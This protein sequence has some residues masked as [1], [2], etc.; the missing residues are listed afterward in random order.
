[1]CIINYIINHAIDRLGVL[2]YFPS[3]TTSDVEMMIILF[4]E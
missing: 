1:L 4:N 3:T 2:I